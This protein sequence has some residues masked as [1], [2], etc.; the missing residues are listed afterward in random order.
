MLSDEVSIITAVDNADDLD[1]AIVGIKTECAQNTNDDCARDVC[2]AEMAYLFKAL[3]Y[4]YD[5]SKR[6]FQQDISSAWEGKTTESYFVENGWTQDT[7]CE[8]KIGTIETSDKA[9]CGAYP[10]RFP[11]KTL[12]GDR[13]CCAGTGVYSTTYNEDFNICCTDGSLA[14]IGSAC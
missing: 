3:A 13:K 7:D 11:Y 8:R 14:S 10:F 12:G 6:V 9:C 2:I 5:P 4:I 1:T